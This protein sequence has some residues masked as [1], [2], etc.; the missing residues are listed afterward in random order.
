MMAV[1]PSRR[2]PFGH[3]LKHWRHARGLSQLDLA[4]RAGSPQRHISF[5]ETGRARPSEEMVL[6]LCGV[7][8]VPLRERNRML[9][10]AGLPPT[11]PEVPLTA[12]ATRWYRAALTRMLDAHDPYPALAI[13]GRWDVVDVNQTARLLFPTLDAGT[14]L[15]NAIFTPGP[16][17]ASLEHWEAVAQVVLAR[18]AREANAAPSDL[19][20]QALAA[21]ARHHTGD[22]ASV[23]PTDALSICPHFLID[24]QHIR[25]FSMAAQFTAACELTLDE[26]R[27][28]LFFPADDESEQHLR[29]L[30]RGE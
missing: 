7:L 16:L 12:N 24:G 28:E 3:Q 9:T 4:I 21:N 14:N 8:E 15:A 1:P 30:A 17:R 10:L 20:L 13:D 18:L 2:T 19:R 29:R 23:E 27:V 5:L 26:L 11:Y 6:R 25:T 22:A